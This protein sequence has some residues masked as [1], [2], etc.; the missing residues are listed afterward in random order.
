MTVTAAPNRSF[1]NMQVILAAIPNQSP[2]A[3]VDP[4]DL[5]TFPRKKNDRQYIDVTTIGYCKL[6]RSI[7]KTKITEDTCRFIS[8]RR[9]IVPNK[10]NA[11]LVISIGLTVCTLFSKTKCSM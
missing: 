10:I 4:D 5:E 6:P 11:Y 1:T 9:L 2:L 7:H 3:V 8:L